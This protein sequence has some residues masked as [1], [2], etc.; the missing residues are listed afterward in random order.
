ML[1]TCDNVH[2][3]WCNTSLKREILLMQEWN[4]LANL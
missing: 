3:R 1:G 2:Q 4:M